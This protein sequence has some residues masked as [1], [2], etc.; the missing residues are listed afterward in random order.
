MKIC[1]KS[2]SGVA[3]LKKMSYTCRH[4]QGKIRLKDI[5]YGNDI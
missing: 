1:K 2:A 4:I 5:V 3:Q